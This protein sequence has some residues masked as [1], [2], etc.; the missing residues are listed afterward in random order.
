MAGKLSDNNFN[1]A[2]FVKAAL[3]LGETHRN[4]F[5]NAD[6]TEGKLHIMEGRIKDRVG[7][8]AGN[9]FTN[10]RFH[11]ANVGG[12]GGSIITGADFTGASFYSGRSTSSYNQ[13]LDLSGQNFDGC[14]MSS[15]NF[16]AGSFKNARLRGVK[17]NGANLTGVDF[18]GADLANADFLPSEYS[19]LTQLHGADFMGAN[20]SGVNW[21]GALFNRDTKFPAGFDV[22]AAGLEPADAESVP[23]TPLGMVFYSKERLGK[24]RI[25]VC[26]GDYHAAC[27]YGFI[28]QYAMHM[29]T[30][31]YSRARINKFNEI[32]RSLLDAGEI[33]LARLLLY[34]SYAELVDVAGRGTV[35]TAVKSMMEEAGIEN[36]LVTHGED[37]IRSR[38]VPGGSVRA[39]ALAALQAGDKEKARAI[40]T[41][42][43]DKL[44]SY[45]NASV[46]M[47]F[48]LEYA[49]IFS[50][51]D[52][53]LKQAQIKALEPLIREAPY[54][55]F[56]RRDREA[57][58]HKDYVARAQKLLAPPAADSK[59]V[60]FM[61]CV[62]ISARIFMKEN[63]LLL[64]DHI[65]TRQIGTDS[66]CPAQAQVSGGGYFLDGK[67][68]RVGDR[69][70]LAVPFD[71]FEVIVG[72]GKVSWAGQRS[73]EI[74][75]LM[76]GG[77]SV[78]E[79]DLCPE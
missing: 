49:D 38:H 19:G 61:G 1:N 56:E 31:G 55:H 44:K 79:I 7:D 20:L 48:M 63:L 43:F 3:D 74:D 46:T 67:M 65:S 15:S 59:C 24:G 33:E 71:R 70:P 51:L 34:R 16:S 17:F 73:I 11:R 78:Y 27:M 50:R 6:F 2:K 9:D 60:R 57:S 25:Q 4:T 28:I 54:L 26:Y 29:D 77:A 69:T 76:Q 23:K 75:D 18:T 14:N 64:Q 32:A 66:S 35:S 52:G 47:D 13:G 37:R 22:L 68:V 72:R 41:S 36:N 12:L 58:P 40:M 21:E 53:P 5:Q 62:D 45:P 10:A 42:A 8:V 30:G 39:D